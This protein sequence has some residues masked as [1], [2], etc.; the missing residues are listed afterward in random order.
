MSNVFCAKCG[1]ELPGDAIFCT[2]CGK[3]I[4]ENVGEEDSN[5]TC[6]ETMTQS[7]QAVN[8]G[9]ND[10][11][12]NTGT[13]NEIPKPAET[14]E[15]E[16]FT[17]SE[18]STLTSIIDDATA[19]EVVA[20]EISQSSVTTEGSETGADLDNDTSSSKDEKKSDS[21]PDDDQDENNSKQGNKKKK[22]IIIWSS[23]F[24]VI[25]IS[26]GLLVGFNSTNY[27]LKSAAYYIA[28]EDFDTAADILANVNVKPE[29]EE[30]TIIY[31]YLE[32]FIKAGGHFQNIDFN[33][34]NI[35][36]ISE[37]KNYQEQ[38][39]DIVNTT[40]NSVAKSVFD[41]LTVIN[42][43][44]TDEKSVLQF[45]ALN[46]AFEDL[47]TQYD[48]FFDSSNEDPTFWSKNAYEHFSKSI[49]TFTKRYNSFE[50]VSNIPS[51]WDDDYS[52]IDDYYSKC[53]IINYEELKKELISAQMALYFEYRCWVED[54]YTY[55]LNEVQSYVNTSKTGCSKA[56]KLLSDAGISTDYGEYYYV[57]S[58]LDSCESRYE[59]EQE[60]IN[61]DKQKFSMSES[62]LWIGKDKNW[63]ATDYYSLMYNTSSKKALEKNA[64]AACDMLKAVLMIYY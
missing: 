23:I 27:N 45:V 9:E 5:V 38:L 34:E 17:G 40:G 56:R 51:Y 28:A 55:T 18:G 16:Q 53:N 15:I 54:D 62:L 63:N 22:N 61:S 12:D 14:L 59:D 13:F 64:Q 30:A 3:K 39:Y 36:I 48:N 6:A 19:W 32:L 8:N 43:S 10:S 41:E 46:K 33:S 20:P 60:N 47:Q 7:Q 29:N 42:I 21:K 58:F 26:I 57:F 1:A 11:Q 44:E 31:E 4:Y 25:I 49:A 37:L 2:Y 52:Y 35:A 24:T 50:S